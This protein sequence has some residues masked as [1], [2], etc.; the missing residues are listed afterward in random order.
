MM[1]LN[2]FETHDRLQHLHKQADYISQGCQDCINGRPPE[3]ENSPFY[4][5]AFKKQID[6]DERKELF[7]LDLIETLMNPLLPRK[8]RS[9][10]E[11][12]SDRLIWSS[13]LTKPKAQTNSML[14]KCYPPDGIRVIWILPIREQWEQYVKGKLTENEV[15]TQ[16]IYDFEHNREQLEAS[17]EDD[18]SEKRANYIYEQMSLNK[19]PRMSY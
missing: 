5:F 6:L 7:R 4:I 13:R 15:V 17:E 11:V 14:F 18:V 16:S 12:P 3:F 9:I 8:Y 19:K 1:K 10:D 2:F